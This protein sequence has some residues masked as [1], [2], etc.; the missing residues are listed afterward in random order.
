MIIPSGTTVNISSGTMQ[1]A[2]SRH[3]IDFAN[4]NQPI[5]NPSKIIIQPGGTLN[6]TDVIL[7]G[8]N[9]C[10]G[11]NLQWEGIE[12]KATLPAPKAVRRKVRLL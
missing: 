10:L 4:F 8:M 6:L 1:F 11:Q 2:N 5:S 12:L 7:E 9:N 3:T